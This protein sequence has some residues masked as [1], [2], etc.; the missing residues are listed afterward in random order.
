MILYYT[1]V[2]PDMGPTMVVSQ[3]HTTDVPL[4]PPFKTRKKHPDL[5]KLERPVLA[6]A[7][8]LLIFS[9]RTL[10]RASEMTA[11]HGVRLSQHFIWRSAR[12]HFQ[13]YQHW[14]AHGEDEDL[15]RFIA[16]ATPRQREVLGFPRPGDPYWTPETLAAVALRYPTMDMSPYR[17]AT[18]KKRV[19]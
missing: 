13:G 17:R 18:M 15:Q 14:P 5:Y 3:E 1:D 7:G 10:H 6:T 2:P 8:T 4:W 12:H 19:H 16:R 11:D 9:M